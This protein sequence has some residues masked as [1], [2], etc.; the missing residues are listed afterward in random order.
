MSEG[1]VIFLL[2][3]FVGV[4]IGFYALFTKLARKWL[5]LPDLD[6]PFPT[7]MRWVILAGAVHATFIVGWLGSMFI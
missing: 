5:G 6:L 2:A 4:T 1:F 7:P 3:L